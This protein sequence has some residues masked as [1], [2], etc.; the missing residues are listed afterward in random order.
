MQLLNPLIL[1][2]F[3]QYSDF[4]FIN[5]GLATKSAVNWYICSEGDTTA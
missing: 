5:K 4:F 3:M 1:N 2:V